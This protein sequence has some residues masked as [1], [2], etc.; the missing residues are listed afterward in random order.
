MPGRND[1][2][3]VL[4]ERARQ[5][6]IESMD[7]YQRTADAIRLHV[8]DSS[9][10]VVS[11]GKASARMMQAA[12]E[13]LGTRLQ[14]AVVLMPPEH[15]SG[16]QVDPRVTVFPADHPLPTQRNVEASKYVRAF[17][18]DVS[19]DAHTLLVLISGGGS[20]HLALPIDGVTLDDLQQITRELLAAGCSIEEINTV[21]KHCEQ[22]KGGKLAA[23]AHQNQSIERL[24]V[25]IVSDV[26]GNDVP[27]IAS[28]P[29]APD[30]TAIDDAM[31][32]LR[33]IQTDASA[34][35]RNRIETMKEISDQS[36]VWFERVSSHIIASNNDA[37]EAAISFLADAGFL[38]CDV[39]AGVTGSASAW[40]ESIGRW[41]LEGCKSHTTKYE[42]AIWGGETTVDTQGATG[43]GGRCQE[44]ALH[45]ASTWTGRTDGA[46][47]VFAT[48]G[49]DGPTDAAGAVIDRD[50]A[51][52]ITS[53]QGLNQT[54]ASHDS[55]SLLDKHDCLIRC[56]S[57]GTNVNDIAIAIRSCRE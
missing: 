55:Y 52:S 7:P 4:L 56:G 32:I 33:R 24:V 23:L 26:I 15:A 49:I 45:V 27:A 29:F 46:C 39:E 21:R 17:V 14:S 54:I 2:L 3:T 57:T 22:L 16:E 1:D 37:I 30:T 53:D 35:V 43:R 41:L 11:F 13:V 6:V 40:G 10:R 47:I 36:P 12:S 20:A 51:S 5:H 48:D 9:V 19:C 38:V 25:L 34:R 18:S 8:S 50:C 31:M 42:C 28:G 44:A